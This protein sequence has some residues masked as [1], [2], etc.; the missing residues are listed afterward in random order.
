MKTIQLIIIIQLILTA[1]FVDGTAIL[2]SHT[3]S[4]VGSTN[5]QS[6]LNKLE[7]W[8]PR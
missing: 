6:N 8:I 5:L 4:K 1:N 3:G 7:K 2:S